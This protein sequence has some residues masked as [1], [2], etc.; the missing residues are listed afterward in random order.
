MCVKYFLFV[1]FKYLTEPHRI[2]LKSVLKNFCIKIN[3][4]IAGSLDKL[5]WLNCFVDRNVGWVFSLKF[6]GIFWV[7]AIG[8]CAR[9]V[10]VYLWGAVALIENDALISVDVLVSFVLWLVGKRRR[11][12]I[13]NKRINGLR[14]FCLLLNFDFASKFL[15]FLSLC[16]IAVFTCFGIVWWLIIFLWIWLE[17]IICSPL[18]FLWRYL[19]NLLG[20]LKVWNDKFLFIVFGKWHEHVFLWRY[21]PITVLVLLWNSVKFW[22]RWGNDQKVRIIILLFLLFIP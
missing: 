15:P 11:C 8:K 1:V 3:L 14:N 20:L 9:I 5:W 18:D 16:P 19:L 6:E 2:F 13:G 21:E 12:M 10:H 4:L 17:G 7:V 22:V